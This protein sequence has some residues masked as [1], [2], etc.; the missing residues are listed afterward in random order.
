MPSPKVYADYPSDALL[1]E[2]KTRLQEV[3]IPDCL[4]GC[5]QIA[6]MNVVITDSSVAS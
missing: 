6:Q 1:N 3:E 4:P 5:A 2:L